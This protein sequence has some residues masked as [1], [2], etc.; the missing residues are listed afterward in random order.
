[1]CSVRKCQLNMG[2]EADSH[3]CE[4]VGRSTGY[5]DILVYAGEWGAWQWRVWIAMWMPAMTAAMAT[6]SWVFTARPVT[7]QSEEEHNKTTSIIHYSDDLVVSASD[8]SLIS[9]LGL[10]C[11]REWV[12]A[13]LSPV[14]MVGMICGAP[15][16]GVVSDRC[17]RRCTVL[18]SVLVTSISGCLL[19]LIPHSLAWHSLCRFST[20]FGAGGAMVATFVYL[21]EGPRQGQRWRLV[22]ALG[23]HLGWNSG[24]AVLVILSYFIRGWKKLQ[25]TS[26]AASLISL[27]VFFLVPEGPRWL[28][29]Q[30]KMEEAGKVFRSMA[31]V[32][33]KTLPS[34][35]LDYVVVPP[36]IKKEVVP[37]TLIIRLLILSFQ[38]FATNLCYY[39]IH[40][41]SVQLYGD[42]H[43]N[44]SLLLVAEVSANLFSHLLVLP[45]LGQKTYLMVCQAICSLVLFLSCLVPPSYHIL[46]ILLTLA[47]KFTATSSFNCLYFYTCELFPTSIRSTTM[48]VCSTVGRLGAMVALA[49]VHLAWVAEVLPSVVM[50]TPAGVAAL[51]MLT[52][53]QTRN[54]VLPET[55]KDASTIIR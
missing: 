45:H 22:A 49:V 32:N 4:V 35:S 38:W 8:D 48:G 52:L 43:V 18:V 26:H 37:R 12:V 39:G 1:M 7:C 2:Q 28:I 29:S 46:K 44:F 33:K 16:L 42:L 24:Q 6:L 3:K 10:V 13:L 19:V 30:G 14:Y 17:G 27:S 53:P 11:E 36:R 20:G 50:A 54:C 31:K 41:S 25:L 5:E 40:Y 9:S 47:G 21:I 51:L 34:N 23:L 15:V 55:L